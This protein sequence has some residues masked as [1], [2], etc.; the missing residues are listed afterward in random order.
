MPTNRKTRESALTARVIGAVGLGVLALP[1][2]A[3]AAGPEPLDLPFWSVVPFVLLLLCIAILPLAAA[4]FWHN[5]RNKAI[6]VTLLAVPVVAY[7]AYVRVATGQRTLYPLVHELANYASFIIMLGSLYTVAG[8]IVVRGDLRPT[9]WNNVA[10]LI[11]GAVL[12]NVIGTTGSSVLLI[13]P[14]LRI[15]AGRQ[16]NVHLPVFFIFI[17]SNLGG[18][19]TPLGDPPLFMG[20]LHGVPFTWTLRLWPEYLVAN[21][22]VLAAFVVCDTLALRREPAELATPTEGREP[23]RLDGKINLVLLA[24]IMAAVLIESAW[25]PA[26]LDRLWHLFGGELMMLAMAYLSL[27]WTPKALREA[28]SFTWAPL[29]E[30]AILFAGIFVTMVPALQLLEVHG[31]SLGLTEPWQYFWITGLLSSSLDNAPTYLAFATMA[32]GSSDFNLLVEDAVPGLNGPLVLRAISAGSVFMGAL[33]YIAN[34]PNFMI[35]TIAERAS[36][37]MP[38]FFAYMLYAGVLLLPIYVLIT[39]VFYVPR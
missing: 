2:P 33:T 11:V 29:M 24:G 35:K 31:R 20:Y 8:G 17:V 14:F 28:N 37:R 38:S 21:G 6:V 10:L 13:R 4:H 5:D 26:W 23:L 22:L 34:G 12:A 18:S 1:C 7:L 25:F 32:A 3:A 30:V 27:R 9:P 39:F 15:N 19:L 36:Y 16:H